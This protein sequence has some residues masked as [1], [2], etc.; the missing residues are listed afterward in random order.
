[1]LRGHGSTRPPDPYGAASTSAT[2][3]RD[4]VRDT[5]SHDTTGRPAGGQP[6]VDDRL[7]PGTVVAVVASLAGA[8]I[9]IVGIV[10]LARTGIP[11]DLSSVRV[12][13]GPFQRTPIMGA[14]E[15]L[16]GL[17]FIGV[18]ATRNPGGLFALGLVAAVFG[19]VW[20]IE[21]A[22]FNDLLGV[23]RATAWTYLVLGLAGAIAGGW[24]NGTMTTTRVRR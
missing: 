23:G 5:A 19:V 17:S 13:V 7:D 18:G 11:A 2:S 8:F 10:T 3:G 4:R 22:A 6:P 9:L 1:M 24:A 20:L 16:V 12:G 15:V 14:I 21:P